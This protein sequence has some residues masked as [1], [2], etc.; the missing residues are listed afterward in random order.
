MPPAPRCKDQETP[1][2]PCPPSAAFSEPPPQR[3]CTQDPGG[4][5]ISKKALVRARRCSANSRWIIQRQF[6]SDVTREDTS[7]EEGMESWLSYRVFFLFPKMVIFGK[8]PQ[9]SSPL[10]P[11]GTSSYLFSPNCICPTLKIMWGVCCR[12][13][14]DLPA[15]C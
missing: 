9:K 1:P 11:T 7:C 10:T 12:I 5:K 6:Q 3:N 13:R 14:E 2:Q 15:L 8:H 4:T